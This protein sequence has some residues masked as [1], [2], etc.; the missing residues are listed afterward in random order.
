M[1]NGLV[2]ELRLD[3]VTCETATKML[4]GKD[5]SLVSIADD[6]IIQFLQGPGAEFTLITADL[7]LANRCGDLGLSCMKINQKELVL[8]H[9]RSQ[10]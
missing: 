7:K 3:G 6:K 5:D 8:R 1:F 10:I 2:E 4:T 9:I